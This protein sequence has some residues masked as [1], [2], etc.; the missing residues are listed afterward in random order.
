MSTLATARTRNRHTGKA[1]QAVRAIVQ[2]GPRKLELHEFPRPQIGPDEAILRVE[3]CGICGSDI[4]QYT[5]HV[6]AASY[7]FIP[8]HEPLGIIEEIGERAA[9]KWGVSVGDR[10][11]VESL[12]TC[13]VCEHC[14]AGSRNT[15]GHQVVYGFT[16]TTL[17]PALWGAYADYLYLHPDTIVHRMSKKLPASIAA[18]YNPMGA[19]VRWAVNTPSMRVGDTVLILGAGQRGLACVIAAKAA[20]AG[21]IIVTDIATAAH[22]LDLALELGANCAIV[23]DE[24]SVQ[25]RVTDFTAGRMADI[26]VDVC[27]A[28][29]ALVD[30]VDL[31]RWGG[32][33]V[34]AGLK[35]DG[36]GTTLITDKMVMRTISLKG[37]FTVDPRSYRQAIQLIESGVAAFEKLRSGTYELKDAEAAIHRLAGWDG[38]PPGV[39]I[40]IEPRHLQ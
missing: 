27:G 25:Q 10:V 19:G 26:V 24:D 35:G 1:R 36:V 20:G 30:A 29:Q 13:G 21:R 32:T 7:P 16:P 14:L 9:R 37:V 22:K 23:A 2:T 40:V 34:L 39:H 3:A 38:K 15:C 8:G 28:T 33:I 17:A 5:G 12:L 6:K 31:V 4:E 11:A 18:L